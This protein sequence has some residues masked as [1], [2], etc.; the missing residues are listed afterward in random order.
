[1]GELR[2]R[3]MRDMEVRRSSGQTV[4]AY[5]AGVK[6]LATYYGR[7]PDQLSDEEVQRYLLY[8]RD[9]R[10][11]QRFS[12]TRPFR[13]PAASPPEH[14]REVRVAGWRKNPLTL[15]RSGDEE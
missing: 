11:A 9:A 8:V 5:V 7:P 14:S 13:H 4:E 12:S 1:M 3:M 10:R 2:N 6:G 15:A